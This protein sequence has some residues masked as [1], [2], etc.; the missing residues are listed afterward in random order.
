[1][2]RNAALLIL[3]LIS[4]VFA[5]CGELKETSGEEFNAPT[6]K[7]YVAGEVNHP[8]VYEIESSKRIIDA[9][10]MAGGATENGDISSMD[11]AAF[12]DDGQTVRVNAKKTDAPP[13]EQPAEPQ[14]G[15]VSGD[16]A[17]ININTA[18]VEELKTLDGI[19]DTYAKRII[20]YRTVNGNFAAI[21]DI[22]NVSGIGEKRF[23]AIKS[24]ITV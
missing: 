20:E 15:A 19:G 3:L 11:L 4:A 9:I 7:V 10:N 16:T 24:K 22:Q 5:G 14:T 8:D 21:E 1:M 17:K 6:I 12:M 23:K 13:S 18:T 2:K